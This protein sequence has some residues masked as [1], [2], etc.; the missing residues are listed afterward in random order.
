MSGPRSLASR[1]VIAFVLMTVAVAGTL[2]LSVKLA[3]DSV[4]VQLVS[5][6]MNRHLDFVLAELEDGRLHN[7]GP[8]LTLYRAP[9]GDDTALPAFARG[10]AAGFHEF[11]R[12]DAAY[13]ILVRQ[14]DGDRLVMILDQQEFE[15]RENLIQIIVFV[16][17]VLCIALAWLLG[18]LV[19]HTVIAPVVR[20]SGQVQHRDQLLPLAPPLAPDYADDEVG[21]LAAA[22]DHAL[23]ELREALEREQLFTSDVSHELR[24]P[25]MVIA[26]SCELLL[27]VHQHAAR[28]RV[29]V[30][31]IAR[32]CA[33]MRELVET[34]LLLARAPHAQG[35]EARP[36]SLP[37]LAHEQVQRW[38][39]EAESRGLR[40][41]LRVDGTDT[42][43]YPEPQ[44]RAVMS[45]LLRNAIH[46]TDSGFV[47]IVLRAGGF[48]V[49]DSGVGIP[50]EQRDRIFRPFTR[51]DASRGDG[52]G[53]GLSLVQ[54][55]CAHEGWRITVATRD[56]GGCEFRVE[57]SAE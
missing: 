49:I 2:S 21:K 56:G 44:L 25:L 15:R 30:E 10:L 24:T 50:A 1:I 28:T 42:G 20:L 34:F 39:D 12:G 31:R 29:Q 22:F 54:R 19:A 41:E 16:G 14:R 13:H 37:T 38:Q 33:E 23:G 35:D 26:S 11:E 45:N 4:E 3:V 8:D 57:F 46:Y 27:T 47:R 43:H 36:V 5:D 51:G 32:A 53:I 9:A 18:R 40:L 6:S 52:Y 48:A 55:I 7:L 17:F